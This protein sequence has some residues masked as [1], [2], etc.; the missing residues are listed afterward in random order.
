[1]VSTPELDA[2]ETLLGQVLVNPRGF[3]ERL[4]E[5]LLNR[6]ADPGAL[7]PDPAPILA[8]DGFSDL[9]SG[10]SDVTMPSEP[11]HADSNL[12]LAAA[13]GACDCWGSDVTCP[14]C[15]GEGRCGWAEPDAELFDEYVAPA[16]AR[17]HG[18]TVERDDIRKPFGVDI[19][20]PTSQGES[21]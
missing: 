15:R 12:L 7:A 5:Q 3:A 19:T 10:R 21:T 13:L 2:V 8:D 14:I 18:P 4:L 11:G 16:A 6:Y 20:E 1:M 9:A 17:I